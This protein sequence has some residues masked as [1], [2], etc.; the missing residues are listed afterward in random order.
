MDLFGGLG[1][2]AEGWRRRG[3]VLARRR[4][5]AMICMAMVAAFGMAIAS[6]AQAHTAYTAKAWGANYAGQLGDGTT[7]GPEKCGPPGMQTE[8][9]STTPVVVNGLSGVVALASGPVTT[10]S[11][12]GLAVL[13]GG[14]VKAWGPGNLGI[15]TTKG[16]DVPVAPCA[17]GTA[18]E[19][20]GG[21]FLGAVTAISV[22]QGHA[23]ARLS[24]GTV[25]AWGRNNVG[26]V[27]DSTSENKLSPT[28]VCAVGA[29]SPCSE[30]S[31]QLKGVTAVAA[32]GDHS[33]ALLEGG[34]VVAWGRNVA[35]QL[36]NGTTTN[37]TV[38]VEVT[39]LKEVVA[40]AAGEEHSLALLKGG[41]VKAWGAN[42][43]GQLGDGAETNSDVPVAVSGLSGATAIAA[44]Q[45]HSLAITG[46]TVKAWGF[47]ERGQLGDGT[48]AGPEACGL[49]GACSKTPVQVC[50]GSHPGPFCGSLF[51]VS[52]IA[53]GGEHSLALLE[54]GI[55]KTWGSNESG[56]LG[57]GSSEGP[58]PCGP[59]VCSTIPVEVSDMADARGIAG[60]GRF[61]LAFGP[62]PTVAVVRF[63]SKKHGHHARG[64]SKGGT[65]VAITGT[66]FAG[67]RSVKFGSVEAAS[68]TVNSPTSITAV[69]PPHRK[70]I[71]DVT[72]TNVWG[73]SATSEADHFR[74]QR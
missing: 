14:A 39:G 12:L 23:L 60:G 70:G 72:V 33:L 37:S 25:A 20:P 45:N 31:H 57:D 26:Q 62:P 7:T 61:S 21:P 30:A 10:F 6:A 40:I 43:R 50:E 11:A 9:C 51:G 8:A 32:G 74:Y 56:Q 24:G 18:G 17:V 69:S 5:R 58:E 71:V 73:T 52:A 49:N 34:T 47:N 2:Q 15:G 68:F 13:E 41:T 3:R 27:G 64:P 42:T 67:V 38:P 1:L 4:R 36:G 46:G 53:A 28:P 29:T 19:C 65:T 63:P 16:S 66:D 44:G 59:A 48:S 54:H 35:G 55:V 22:G